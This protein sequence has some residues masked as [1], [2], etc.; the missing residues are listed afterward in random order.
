MEAIS[1]H[2]SQELNFLFKGEVISGLAEAAGM[3]DSR[4]LIPNRLKCLLGT[5]NKF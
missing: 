2:L 1:R 3:M 4:I 5:W